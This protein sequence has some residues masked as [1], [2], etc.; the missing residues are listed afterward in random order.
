MIFAGTPPIILFSGNSFVITAFAAITHPL[1]TLAPSK[2]T[3][4]DPI[5]QLSPILI[6][7]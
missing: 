4:P 1:A 3:T 2:K 7:L 5:Q 6:P